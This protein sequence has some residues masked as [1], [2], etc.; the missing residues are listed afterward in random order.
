[1]RRRI[2]SVLSKGPNAPRHILARMSRRLQVCGNDV[3]DSEGRMDLFSLLGSLNA[4]AY[5]ATNI[6]EFC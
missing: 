2:S 4:H 5:F 1:M 3:P 6:A